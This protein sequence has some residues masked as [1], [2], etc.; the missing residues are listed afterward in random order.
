M[1]TLRHRTSGGVCAPERMFTRVGLGGPRTKRQSGETI[2]AGPL[3]ST[4]TIVFASLNH[5][6]GHLDG[7]LAILSSLRSQI[8]PLLTRCYPQ[9]IRQ[10]DLKTCR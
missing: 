7:R 4:A 9:T 10:G 1:K 8:V 2:L 5:V 3:G 6:S